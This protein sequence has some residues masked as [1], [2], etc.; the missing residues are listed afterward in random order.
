MTRRTQRLLFIVTVIYGATFLWLATPEQASA[1]RNIKQSVPSPWTPLMFTPLPCPEDIT[2]SSMKDKAHSG[3]TEQRIRQFLE[4]SVDNLTEDLARG[5]GEYLTALVS[6]LGTSVE[7]RTDL[8]NR[9]R[10]ATFSGPGT[11]VSPETLLSLIRE[12]TVPDYKGHLTP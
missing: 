5:G 7:N 6:L 3:S 1:C 9:L 8:T 10:E 2:S 12:Q 11:S 4:A